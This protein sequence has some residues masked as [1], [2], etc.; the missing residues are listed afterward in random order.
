MAG[1]HIPLI[2]EFN[3]KGIKKAIEQFKK[4]ET[5][6]Q[7]AQF[8]IRKAAVPATA[9]L[10]GLAAAA[11]EFAKV[12]ADD[13]RSQIML[14]VQLKNSTGATVEQTNAVT[15]Q[16]TA[17]SRVSAVANEELRPAFAALALGTHSVSKA[18]GLMSTVLDTAAATG[19]SASEVAM[20]LG[21]AYQGN[22]RSLKTLSPEL[23]QMI[24][25]HASFAQVVAVL[26]KNFGGTNKALADSAS[27]GFAKMQ[28]A[29]HE[30]EVSIGS[31]LLPVVEA[32][33]RAFTSF[34]KWAEKNKSL[35][36]TLGLT[37]GLMAGGIVAANV[38]LNAWKIVSV[39]TEAVNYALATSFTAV[40]IATGIGIATAIIGAAAFIKIKNSMHAAAGAAN[41]YNGAIWTTIE[42]QKQLNAYIGPVSSRDFDTFKKNARDAAAAAAALGA[43]TA[44]TAKQQDKAAA[45][46]RKHSDALAKFK[47]AA[48]A[49]KKETLDL[50]QA[51]RDKLATQL[52]AA[53]AKVDS[54]KGAF[55]SF[56]DLVGK[57]I[58]GAFSFG[59][60]QS[61]ASG[62]AGELKT[63][64]DKQA[65]A[66]A[67][68]NKA[69]ADF[70]YFQR[71]DYALILADAMGEL[72]VATGEV[73][74]A[75]AKP[76][77][78]FD[79]LAKQAQKAKDFGV[80]VNRLIA[81]GL[82]DTALQQVLAAGVDGG[83]AIATEILS[84]ADGVLK[85]NTLTQ[86]MTDLAADM[87]KRA[88]AKYYGA[89]VDSATNFLKGIQDTIKAVEVVL[90]KPDLTSSDVIG[91]Y[92][93]QMTPA[94]MAEFQAQLAA[95]LQGMNFG[96]GT[97]MASGGI[98][99]SAQTITAGESGPEAIIPLDRAGEFGLGGG[100]GGVTINVNGGDPNAV[101]AALRTYMRQNGS[102][103]IRVSNIY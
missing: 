66:Q 67:K 81:A 18:Q 63:A 89:G 86:S 97:L 58:T 19:R 72:A 52:D 64:L 2:T 8:A 91:A 82:S 4:L 47:A 83:S 79:A 20:A 38:A 101:V 103:P 37:F 1:I 9:A 33:A 17:L 3:D 21:R 45:A 74:K 15:E 59:D 57:A 36:L 77:T 5:T 65:E 46:A 85:A 60:A 53:Q 95:N 22:F 26:N 62:N 102:I 40:Q 30:A 69:Q 80:L 42:N 39:I 25:N 14:A 90:A 27:G 78:F 24:K 98:V 41:E 99:T 55:E 100:G 54:A 13:Q 68:V 94:D 29:L 6:G 7:Q 93:G 87:G 96:M 35:I 73:T 51:L 71:D 34:G 11:G 50:A 44:D 31:A 32:M 88:A 28:I 70:N 23:M 10:V 49:A 76:M 56:A 84:S 92:M 61:E 16:L 48:E 43:W 75:Q 12:A